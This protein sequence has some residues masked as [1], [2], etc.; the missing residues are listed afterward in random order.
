MTAKIFKVSKRI[1]NLLSGKR[2][3]RD[4]SGVSAME[5]A[6]AVPIALLML[7]AVVEF[8]RAVFT[9]GMM[10]YAAEEAT[11]WGIVNPDATAA[12]IQEY[13]N[14][15]LGLQKLADHATIVADPVANPDDTITVSV[16][17]TFPYQLAIPF[18]NL[19]P[20]TLSASSEG[21]L[22]PPLD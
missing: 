9:Q 11:R 5:F 4:E 15:K 17:I 19:A 20:I 14:S 22:A 12:E 21:F 13:A 6:I 18:G 16:V 2:A 7:F 3:V 10:F 1:S 8:G